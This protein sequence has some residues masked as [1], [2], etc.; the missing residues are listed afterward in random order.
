MTS[1]TNHRLIVC[2]LLA[3]APALALAKLPAAN[4]TPEEK[5]KAAEAAAK[6][7]WGNKVADFQLCKSMDKAAA[8][9]FEV[10]KQRGTAVAA[11]PAAPACTDPGPFKAP[12]AAGAQAP[13]AA[14]AAKTPPAEPPKK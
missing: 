8:N 4:P 10:A 5:A 13:S 2:S 12:E 14:A 11:D 9:H 1:R 3:V 6:A 7:A